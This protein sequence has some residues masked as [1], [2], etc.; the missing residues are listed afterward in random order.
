MLIRFP[1]RLVIRCLIPD[2]PRS[3]GA[4]S[5][6]ARCPIC[7]SE[8]LAKVTSLC[9]V[10]VGYSRQ[11]YLSWDAGALTIGRRRRARLT[12]TGW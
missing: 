9:G 11:F 7:R 5:S 6:S 12:A 2:T 4:L 1:F 10:R 3:W 8:A